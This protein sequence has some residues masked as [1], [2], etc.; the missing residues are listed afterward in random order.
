M[1][2]SERLR[3]ANLSLSTRLLRS[4]AGAPVLLLHGSPDSAGEWRLAME[5]LDMQCACFAPDLPGLGECDEPPQAFDYSRLATN[6]FLD[7]LLLALGVREPLVLVVHDI[8]GAIGIPWA[9]THVD[10][11]RGLVI[12]NTVVFEQF[13]WFILAKI[14]ARTGTIGRLVASALM[15][16]FGWLGGRIFRRAF[17]RIS[18]ELGERDL[19]RITREFALDPKSKRCTLRL[20]RR[21]VPPA[22][23]DGVDAMVSEL[24]ARVPVRV[25]W[26]RGDPYIPARYADAFAGAE[27]EIVEDGGHWIPISAAER[28]A[29]AV[30]VVLA[31]RNG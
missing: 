21:M 17:A 3:L 19:E 25:V 27:R 23:F 18:P 10:R 16:Q 28:V 24:I 1:V 20:F 6:A 15:C 8:G 30:R 26:G 29:A 4:G 13:P 22:Y 2:T 11:I 14:W 12:T 5:A 7:Q 31:A 9:A